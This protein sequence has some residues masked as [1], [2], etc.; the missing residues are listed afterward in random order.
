ME[1]TIPNEE[2]PNCAQI[3]IEMPEALRLKDHPE[4]EDAW[5]EYLV[6]QWEPWAEEMRRWQEVQ[7]I[8]E[9]VDFMRRRLEEA[10]ERYELLAVVPLAE[11]NG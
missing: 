7:H 3:T 10:E 5:L 11:T 1:H 8:Y 6:N 4:V 9:D 2:A